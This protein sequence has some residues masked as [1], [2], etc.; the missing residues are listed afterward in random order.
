L[1]ETHILEADGLEKVKGTG[2]LN[3][4]HHL[5][6]GLEALRRAGADKGR[7]EEVH[8]RL[9]RAQ[10][11]SRKEMGT[12]AHEKID[13]S[14][15]KAKA[16]E[17]VSGCGLRTALIRLAMGVDP[18]E[19]DKLRAEVEENAKNFPFQ[20]LVPTAIV[21]HDGRVIGHRPSM[22]TNDPVQYQAALE[23]EMF[24]QATQTQWPSRVSD[25][26]EPAMMQIF[27]EYRPDWRDLIGLVRHNPFVP[28]GHEEF[29]VRGIH[30]GLTGDLVAVAHYLA[31]QV[32]NSI[33]FVLEQKG[34]ITSKFNEKQIQEVRTLDGLLQ[35]PQTLELFGAGHIFELRG[36]LSEPLGW[37]LRNRVAH[38][39]ITVDGCYTHASIM[40]WWL[41]V[42][43]CVFPL[44][45][46]ADE[47]P[48]ADPHPPEQQ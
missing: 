4:T 16:R 43:F 13:N 32:E 33:R 46:Q 14:E 5:S 48:A 44:V 35:L 9:L 27:E 26:I 34:V 30:A 29:F 40:L 47:Q 10:K 19:P 23:G 17:T 20:A 21:D 39:L 11:Q 22:F 6:S 45:L 3:I 24:H 37:N 12:F 7:I 41:V 18:V 31:P 42:R 8:Q 1:D 25:F 38:G 28:P 2:G 36:V 15:L